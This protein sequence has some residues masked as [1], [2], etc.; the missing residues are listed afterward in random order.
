LVVYQFVGDNPTA[1][2]KHQQVKK[3][4]PSISLPNYFDALVGVVT[5]ELNMNFK[6]ILYIELCQIIMFNFSLPQYS[7]GFLF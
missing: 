1:S 7:S 4:N 6:T 2:G 5:N 3:L